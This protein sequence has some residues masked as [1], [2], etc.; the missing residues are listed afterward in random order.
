[1][2][3]ILIAVTGA[4][5]SVFAKVLLDK[6]IGLKNQID[7]ISVVMS[8]NAVEVSRHELGSDVL[9]QYPVKYYV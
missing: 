1:M 3:K 7:E 9:L 2:H 4:S 5:G 8:S 6:L